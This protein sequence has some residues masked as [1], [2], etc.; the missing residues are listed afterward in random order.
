MLGIISIFA[1]IALSLLITR[2]ATVALSLTGLSR[3][4]ARFQARSALSGAGFTTEESEAVVNHPVRRRVIMTL[5]LVG[6]AG[7]VTAVSTVILSFG[8]GTEDRLL[9]AAILVVALFGL[10]L[11]SRSEALDRWLSRMI[12]KVLRA[13]GFDVRDYS[14]LLRLSGEYAIGEIFVEAD[15]WVQGHT[16]DSLRLR[17]EGIEVLGIERADG[18][19]VGVPE[20]ETQV[21]AG[22]TLIVY[23]RSEQ[24]ESLDERHRI[25]GGVEHERGVADRQRERGGGP[26]SAREA[27]GDR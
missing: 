5:V 9:R 25:E 17:A 19:Y 4:V 11:A 16:L 7:L 20:G 12:E 8:G 1:V 27:G 22:D 6:S 21:E 2:I 3:E 15:D 26:Q 24:I 14:N 13:R 23:A 10:W 18:G